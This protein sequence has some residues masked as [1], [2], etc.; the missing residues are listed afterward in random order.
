MTN[1]P[2]NDEQSI[3]EIK[4]EK[5]VIS[6]S[7][8]FT[9]P[10]T[11]SNAELVASFNHYVKH[12]NQQHAADIATGKI[13]ALAE[14]DAD[15][16]VKASGIH[17]RHVFN[18]SGV[19]DPHIMCPTISERPDDVLSVQAATAIAAAKEAMTNADKTADDIDCVI[20]ACTNMQRPYP[21]IA[22]EVQNA[23]GIK[24]YAFDMGAACSSVTFGIQ[25]AIGAITSG[26][27]HCVLLINPEIGTSQ[28]NFRDRESHFI[29]GDVANALIIE[30][31]TTATA[32]HQ[33][34]ILSVKL[35]TEFS[36]NIRCN[37]GY[38][39]R[40]EYAAGA[41]KGDK[42]FKQ[43]GRKV[44]REVIPM[45]EELITQHLV[46]YGIA[47][48]QL[49][50]LWLHQANVNMNRLIATKILGYEP[51][52]KLAPVVLDEYAN[53][54]SGGVAVAFHKYHADLKSGDLAI[55]CSFGAGYSIGNLILQKI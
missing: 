30:K 45:V 26:Q 28:L 38:L 39:N 1:C 12:Y 5:I 31:Q 9:P 8:T 42:L 41:P 51:D 55:M 35:K 32:Q 15:F 46:D 17:S 33:F 27:A 2:E 21:A 53:T 49:K 10:E 37:F 43:N 25:A 13:E 34:A 54:G 48:N 36:N 20:T 22:I 3:K 29:F 18:K 19:L 44:F 40:A 47:P 7:G 14:S 52:A 11:I 16:I 4:V 50:R 24:G 6:G 23:L